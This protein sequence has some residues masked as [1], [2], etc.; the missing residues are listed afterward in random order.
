MDELLDWFREADE[1]LRNAQPP[2][3]DPPPLR[4]QLKE[5]RAFN[6]D[7]SGQRARVRDVL[8]TA[9]KVL[10]ESQPSED[11]SLMRDK[12]EE[13][14]ETMETVGQLSSDRLGVLEQAL[15]LAEHF[16]DTHEE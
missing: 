8:S 9:K 3:C 12:M 5:H 10:R 1:R 13:L 6:D 16:A 14:R 15:P 7:V 2:G 11:T 4:A